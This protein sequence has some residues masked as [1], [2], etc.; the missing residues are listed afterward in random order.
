MAG[1][2]REN[3]LPWVQ[4]TFRQ[5]EAEM[6]TTQADAALHYCTSPICTLPPPE[7]FPHLYSSPS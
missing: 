6:R 2:L 4:G 5:G 1:P 3:E 7:F